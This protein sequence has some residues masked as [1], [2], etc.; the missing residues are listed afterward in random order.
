MYN[1]QDEAVVLVS[2]KARGNMTAAAI[3]SDTR[4]PMRTEGGHGRV[5]LL[6]LSAGI[7]CIL[8][9]SFL[10]SRGDV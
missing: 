4:A 1:I 8:E 7:R 5:A 2:I 10:M 9:T 3:N 6:F